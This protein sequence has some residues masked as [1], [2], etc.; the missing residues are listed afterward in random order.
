MF[1][2]NMFMS[3]YAY[4]HFQCN[5]DMRWKLNEINYFTVFTLIFRYFSD[6]ASHHRFSQFS[7]IY[8]NCGCFN[9]LQPCVMRNGCR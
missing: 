4:P 7:L 2:Q 9:E 6:F 3:E 8:S 1:G 5:P